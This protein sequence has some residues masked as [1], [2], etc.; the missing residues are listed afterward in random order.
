[1]FTG[2]IEELGTVASRDGSRLRIDCSTVLE[3]AS[4]GDSTAVNGCCLTIV[5]FD[6]NHGWWEADV[7]DET[8]LRT[9]LGA[10]EVGDPVNLERP[11]RLEDRLGGHLVQGHVDAVGEIVH[12]VPDL[13]IRMPASL[14]RYV[15]EKGSITVDGISLTVVKPLDDGFTVAVIPHTSAVTTLGQKGPGSPVNLEV[16][17]MAKYTERLIEAQLAS[18]TRSEED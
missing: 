14:L 3:G 6:A 1:M 16:D 5:A 7:S 15:V 9:N 17:V 10:L 18:L 2:I 11:V 12:A 13:Q 8:F 4:I